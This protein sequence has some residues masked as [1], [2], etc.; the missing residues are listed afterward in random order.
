MPASRS[1]ASQ[2]VSACSAAR[3]GQR[4]RRAQQAVLLVQNADQRGPDRRPGAAWPSPPIQS[5]QASRAAASSGV[6]RPACGGQAS[7]GPLDLAFLVEIR[8]GEP[9]VQLQRMAGGIEDGAAVDDAERA[10][11]AQAKAFEHG[12][13]VPGIDRL[14]VDR[15]LAAHRVEPGAVQKGRQQRVAGERLVEPGERGGGLREGGGERRIDVCRTRR[16]QQRVEQS[17]P[18]ADRPCGASLPRR[19]RPLRRINGLRAELTQTWRFGAMTRVICA[20]A[21]CP[22]LLCPIKPLVGHSN[23]A[24]L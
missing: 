21:P 17:V 23:C 4:H 6:R 3:A 11:H 24:Q 9:L 18:P 8:R 13:E 2:G 22:G 14:A 10:V 15:G 19:A 20:E 7:L 16:A 1:A 5:T 12:G